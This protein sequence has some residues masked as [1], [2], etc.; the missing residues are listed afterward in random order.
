MAGKVSAVTVLSRLRSSTAVSESNP[1]SVKARPGSTA[2]A[3]ACP[4]TA[5]AWSRTTP[6]STRS[7]SATAN[8]ANWR[9]SDPANAPAAAA[10][11]AGTP[12]SPRHS[13]G[14]APPRAA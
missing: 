13:G 10:G 5:A 4:S 2:A 11:R 1:S 12:P 14:R 8:P 3:E 7:C 6:V 9:W